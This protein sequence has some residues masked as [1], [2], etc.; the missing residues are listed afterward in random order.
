[1]KIA[2]EFDA[3]G[4]AQVQQRAGVEHHEIGGV[5][6]IE[7]IR[8]AGTHLRD[9]A[10]EKAAERLGGHPRLHPLD[11][12]E[13]AGQEGDDRVVGREQ[14]GRGLGSTS[15]D[16]GGVLP[17][18]AIVITNEDTG[19]FREVTSGSDGSY[20]ASQLTPGRYRMAAK[21]ASFRTFERGGLLLAVG[22]QLAEA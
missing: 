10:L 6:E 20:F 14:I 21:L 15:D 22:K 13:V 18:V 17:G 4:R 2:D 19:V 7:E 1:M 5:H 12:T 8:Q 9:V 3:A 11:A 16:Q